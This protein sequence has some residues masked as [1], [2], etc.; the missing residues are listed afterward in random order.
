MAR[1]PDCRTH[2]RCLE[3]EPADECPYCGYTGRC[4]GCKL[5]V[6]R[7]TCH[8]REDPYPDDGEDMPMN[9]EDDDDTP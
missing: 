9:Q 7:C 1:C 4:P 6:E 3:D 8:H 2:F 5:S